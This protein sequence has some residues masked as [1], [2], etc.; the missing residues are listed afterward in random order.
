MTTP[1]L[2]ERIGGAAAV[3]AAVDLFYKKIMADSSLSPFFAKTDLKKQIGKQ[4]LFMTYAFGGA[5]HY[6]GRKLREAHAE[7]VRNDLNEK[8][9]GAVAT[10]LHTTLVELKVA[11]ALIAEVMA[12][13]GSTKNEVLGRQVMHS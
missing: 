1:T 12:I 8:H 6:D 10:H 3:N 11:P 13:V 4:Q 7:A 5:S 9:F 2:Y